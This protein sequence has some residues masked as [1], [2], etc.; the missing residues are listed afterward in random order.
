MKIFNFVTAIIF[1]FTT[2]TS[3]A[4]SNNATPFAE[5]TPK[6]KFEQTLENLNYELNCVWDQKD[7]T[8]YETTVTTFAKEMADL[9]EE[10]LTVDEIMS[11]VTSKISDEKVKA[12]FMEAMSPDK[13]SVLD[14]DELTEALVS[15]MEIMEEE[16][17]SYWSSWFFGTTAVFGGGYVAYYYTYVYYY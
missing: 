6:E 10:G 15:N 14:E 12:D 7:I 2:L 8:F 11:V 9:K 1:T 16:G 4:A 3:F 13:L 17:S 5:D